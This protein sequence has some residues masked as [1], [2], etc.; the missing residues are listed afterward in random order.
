MRSP[1]AMGWRG[2][3]NPW[4]RQLRG[5][6]SVPG[7]HPLKDWGRNP[8]AECAKLRL[9]KAADALASAGSPMDGGSCY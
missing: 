4:P 2:K 5:Q 1:D 7:G 9:R 6:H 8:R 3:P